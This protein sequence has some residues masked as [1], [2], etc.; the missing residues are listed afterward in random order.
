MIKEFKEAC[1]KFG[2]T[3]ALWVVTAC[4]SALSHYYMESPDH[5]NAWAYG[6]VIGL[7][8]IV[9]N[10]LLHDPHEY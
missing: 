5:P 1:Y 10:A 8:L 3:K 2:L 7:G 6:F 9:T 4:L